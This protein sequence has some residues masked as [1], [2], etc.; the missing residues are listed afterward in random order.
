MEPLESENTGEGLPAASGA[1][2]SRVPGALEK[3]AHVEI[4]LAVGRWRD[5]SLDDARRI[6]RE[7]ASDLVAR[8]SERE[9]GAAV[10]ASF[11][12]DIS[13]RINEALRIQMEAAPAFEKSAS[14]AL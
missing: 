6:L 14:H 12:E 11:L 4:A 13:G 10:S 9:P 8:A 5:G 3:Q 2:E 1:G 7:L